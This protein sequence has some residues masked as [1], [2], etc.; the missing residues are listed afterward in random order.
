[1]QR[2]LH[3]GAANVAPGQA[4]QTLRGC[5]LG[6]FRRR[7]R[8]A[9]VNAPTASQ[10]G[11]LGARYGAA[12]SARSV[13]PAGGGSGG[14][15]VGLYPGGGS[16][17][18]FEDCDTPGVAG[19]PGGTAAVGSSPCPPRQWPAYPEPGAVG[20]VLGEIPGCPAQDLPFRRSS[21]LGLA[22]GLSRPPGICS[23]PNLPPRPGH[24]LRDHCQDFVINGARL[25]AEER[26]HHRCA[27]TDVS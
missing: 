21:L 17:V 15:P 3:G 9:V 19:V 5:D 1:M 26:P 16:G 6:L 4:R 27:I 8:G 20:V 18:G 12:A 22:T 13:C 23:A 14:R 10:C 25:P 24:R 11:V 2:S 7:V